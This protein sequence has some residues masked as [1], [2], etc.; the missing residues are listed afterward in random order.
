M[1]YFEFMKKLVITGASGF[2]GWNLCNAA[3]DEWEVIG[4][5][6]THDKADIHGTR[7][8]LDLCDFPAIDGLFNKIHPGAVIHTA[9]VADANICQ[10]QPDQT[11]AINVDAAEYIARQCKKYGAACVF[12]STD[13]VFDGKNSPFSETSSAN[14]MS[15]Y[16]Q[17]KI[18]AEKLMLDANEN[19]LICRLPLMFGDSP[20][21]SRNH[22]KTLIDAICGGNEVS[23]FIDEFRSM[24]SGFD[25]A[26][27][28]LRFIGE[29]RGILHLGG[30]R[31]VSRY[32]FGMAVA[33]ALGIK[34][35]RIKPAHQ[36]DA[37]MAA[38][39]PA[40]VSL[41]SSKARSLGWAPEDV[42]KA[43]QKL[44]C[45]RTRTARG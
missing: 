23:L 44:A 43:L 27:G 20:Q 40:D 13:L 24:V 3:K 9:A 32:N 36:K 39:R 33:L 25:A 4:I 10:V 6:H 16:A 38:P 26:Q 35:P 42:E 11:R 17:Q 30:P 5:S 19:V 15:V 28:I 45:I 8:S 7:V 1:Q 21:H 2:L 12:T 34:D 37:V 29:R 18:E 14:P 22:L 41:D 31:S